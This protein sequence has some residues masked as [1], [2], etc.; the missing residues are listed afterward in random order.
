M[1]VLQLSVGCAEGRA[2]MLDY[3]IKPAVQLVGVVLAAHNE[4]RARR[5]QGV[6]PV[7]PECRR[8]GEVQRDNGF[9]DAAFAAQK[10]DVF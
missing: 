5:R 7:A 3:S 9:S 10:R 6:E 2:V 4:R 1:H 8:H